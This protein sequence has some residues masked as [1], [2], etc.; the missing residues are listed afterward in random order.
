MW[1]IRNALEMQWNQNDI[2]RAS[3]F[4]DDEVTK[5]TFSLFI[6]ITYRYVIVNEKARSIIAWED[7]KNRHLN[8]FPVS[9]VKD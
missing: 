3:T 4:I 1:E 2:W 5:K 7:G 8:A 6:E 9:Y